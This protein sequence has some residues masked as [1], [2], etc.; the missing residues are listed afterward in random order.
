[1]DFIQKTMGNSKEHFENSFSKAEDTVSSPLESKTTDLTSDMPSTKTMMESLA[2][3][4][5]SGFFQAN[6]LSILFWGGIVLL[7]AFLG[8]NL[9]EYLGKFVD[10]TNKLLQPILSKTADLV[11]DTTKQ[12]IN[13]TSEGTKSVV[14]VAQKTTTGGID[15][16]QKQIGKSQGSSTSDDSDDDSDD[17]NKDSE[18][19]K[20]ATDKTSTTKPAT[21]TK[22]D[23]TST[24]EKTSTTKPVPEVVEVSDPDPYLAD[25]SV[26]SNTLSGKS[27]KSGYCYIGTDNGTRTCAPVGKN[28]ECMSGDIFPTNE[29]CMD[30]DLRY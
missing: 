28:N 25:S 5:V 19:D 22:P 17:D 8:F 15:M 3:N 21:T 24:A 18:K 6:W 14:D 27:G 2:Y 13:V 9:F 20:T 10:T 1:M 23:Q 7:I 4:P 16:L 11:G 26:Q 30:P 29:I 12:A